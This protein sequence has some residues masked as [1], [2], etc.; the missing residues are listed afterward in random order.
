MSDFSVNLVGMLAG[1]LTSISLLPQ[2]LK[3]FRTGKVR[4]ISFYMYLILASG[5]SLWII[6]GFLISS[7]PIILANI[8][9]LVFCVVILLNKLF[10]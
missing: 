8:L 9:S 1:V 4:D 10:R 6:Y 2:L 3:I 5:I 7:I